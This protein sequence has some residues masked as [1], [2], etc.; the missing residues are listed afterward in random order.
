MCILKAEWFLADVKM[1]V[2][3]ILICYQ[4][5]MIFVAVQ[6]TLPV[7]STVGTPGL[8]IIYSLICVLKGASHLIYLAKI[9]FS[10]F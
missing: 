5:L 10:G 1:L 2:T 4:F 7:V 9:F 6:T 3:M 8:F